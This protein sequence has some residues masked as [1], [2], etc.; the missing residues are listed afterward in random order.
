MSA[1]SCTFDSPLGE[2]TLVA[3]DQG[4]AG[5]SWPGVTKGPGDAVRHDDHPVLGAAREQLG[6]YFAGD[7]TTFD[8]PLAPAGTDFQLAAWDVLR[9]IPYAETIT[10]GEQARRLG[11]PAKARAVGGANGRNPIPIVVP[12][13]RVVGSSGALVG[14]TGGLDIKRWLLDFERSQ[15][16]G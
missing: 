9:T 13:H 2:L 1:L 10:Y 8:L 15:V 5:V 16:T 6:E 12:C 7:R 11:D 3:T 14:F 4:L